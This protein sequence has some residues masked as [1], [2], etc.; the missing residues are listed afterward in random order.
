G[1]LNSLVSVVLFSIWSVFRRCI[2]N[3]KLVSGLAVSL[4]RAIH[5]IR[6]ITKPEVMTL[7]IWRRYHAVLFT[8]DQ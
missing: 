1:S 6:D 5:C 3:G 7:V 8:L 4:R 2:G